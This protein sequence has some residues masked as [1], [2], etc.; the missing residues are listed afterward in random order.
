MIDEPLLLQL[1]GIGMSEYEAKVYAIL[2]ALRVA[3]GR[4]IHEQTKIPRGRVYETLSALTRK[5]YII[6]TGTSPA[7]YSP[8][9]VSQTLAILKH[10]SMKSLE[11]LHDRLKSL[12]TENTETLMQSYPLHTEWTRDNQIRMML[13]RAK[14]EIV[15]LCDDEA[16]LARYGRDIARAARRVTLYLVVG[17]EEL[18]PLAPVAC[19]IGGKDIGSFFFHHDT[20]E[21]LGRTLKLHLMADRREAVSVL[22]ED[23]KLTGMFICPDIYA[24]YLSRKVI[25]DSRRAGR[26]RKKG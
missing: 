1:K 10:E 2:T 24:S 21:N 23:G 25:Q 16:F 14:S 26:V 4:E 5:G 15:L 7:R 18:V 11:R 22:E 12:E 8:V 20:T 13:A 17:R 19:Y 3:S 6:S 9:D